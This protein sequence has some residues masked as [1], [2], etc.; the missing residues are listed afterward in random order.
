MEKPRIKPQVRHLTVEAAHAGRRL[1]NY[2]LSVL[3]RVPM[4]HIYRV[5]RRGE[6]RVN[7]GRARPSRR[8]ESGD[9]LRVPPLSV[10]A[11][12]TPP[13]PKLASLAALEDAVLYE[14]DALVVLDKPA[15]MA[16]HAGARHSRGAAELLKCARP[17]AELVAPAHR[18]DRE[19]SGCM[20]FVKTR[21]A[22]QA[23]HAAFRTRAVEKTY[24]ALL[25]GAPPTARRRVATPV[26]GRLA[27]TVFEP[28]ETVG[29]CALT[30]VVP[31]TG[32]SHQIRIHASR[33]GF[34]LAGDNRYGDF[35]VNRRLAR[36]GLRRLF[37]HAAQLRIPYNGR[38]LDIEAPL[39]AALRAVLE[40]LAGEHA[41]T[42]KKPPR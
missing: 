37:L 30:R 25:A 13:P 20:A 17:D 27:E 4:S 41:W 21:R 1:D 12:A 16:A 34:P 19:T 8:V 22:M 38:Q 31:V 14:D 7:G 26:T 5:I 6:V 35:A 10:P 18:L 28:L 23:L 33:C 36:L 32:R 9:L 29:D 39:P 11:P 24:L 2:L 40:R 15:G 42:H 3:G